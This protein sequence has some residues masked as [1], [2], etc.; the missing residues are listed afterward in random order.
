MKYSPNTML[1]IVSNPGVYYSTVSS[2][3]VITH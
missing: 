3:N 1:L 2:H